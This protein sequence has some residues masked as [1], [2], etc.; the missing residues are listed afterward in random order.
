MKIQTIFLIL[1]IG[2]SVGAC[3][4]LRDVNHKW[5]PPEA[6]VAKKERINLSADALFKFDKSSKDDLLPA[7][8]ATLTH[9][10]EELVKSKSCCK[11][12]LSNPSQLTN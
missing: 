9:L 4:G 8:K 12:T 2:L 1:G 11:F 10:A 3:S 5:C 6:P 7:G